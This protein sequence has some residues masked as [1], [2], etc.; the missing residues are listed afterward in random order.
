MS[1]N[2]DESP[3]CDCFPE[4]V[5]VGERSFQLGRFQERIFRLMRDDKALWLL[6]ILHV[7]LQEFVHDVFT[8]FVVGKK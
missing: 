1:N 4:A 7:I 5:G 8:W 3:I 6:A 2:Y